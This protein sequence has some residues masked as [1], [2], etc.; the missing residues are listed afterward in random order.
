MYWNLGMLGEV[1]SLYN[2]LL[3]FID[4]KNIYILRNIYLFILKI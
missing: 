1:L 4:E 3:I 2:L